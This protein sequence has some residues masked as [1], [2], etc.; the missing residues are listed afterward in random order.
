M[1]SAPHRP[2][3]PKADPYRIVAAEFIAGAGPNGSLPPPTSVEIAFAG[4][5]NVGKSSLINT[6]VERKSLVRTSSTPGSTRQINLYEVRAADGLVV[7]F[8]DLPGYGFTRRSKAETASWAKLIEGY[9]ATRVTLAAVAVLIDVRRGLEDDD[10]ELIDFIDATKGASRR[11]VEVILVAT[12]LD[13]VPKS[14][15]KSAILTIERSLDHK[16]IGFS[17]VTKDGRIDLWR[18]L[19]RAALGAAEGAAGPSPDQ[20]G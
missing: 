9:L 19:R 1:T 4:R 5:S 10:R 11:P 16:V 2:D 12:K 20:N 3:K 14:A 17:A 15:R 7:R 8:S 6:L 18:A 13:K